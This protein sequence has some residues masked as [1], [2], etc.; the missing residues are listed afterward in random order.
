MLLVVKNSSVMCKVC[1]C[2][3]VKML[4]LSVVLIELVSTNEINLNQKFNQAIF[5]HH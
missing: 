1:V 5:R 3:K 2:V 4:F